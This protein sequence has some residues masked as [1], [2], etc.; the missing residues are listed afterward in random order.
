MR[1]DGVPAILKPD[2]AP[3]MAV[4]LYQ[5]GYKRRKVRCSIGC[6]RFG[7]CRAVAREKMPGSW[8]AE[9]RRQVHPT[10]RRHAKVLALV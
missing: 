7:S 2:A 9:L 6:E 4:A 1:V 10:A 3:A 5:V 8:F